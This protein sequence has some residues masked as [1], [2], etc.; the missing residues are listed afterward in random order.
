M[1][2]L[3]RAVF[4]KLSGNITYASQSVPVYDEKKSV[5]SSVDLYILLGRQTESDDIQDDD[6]FATTSTIEIEI[7]YKTSF[8]TSKEAVHSVSNQILQ[9]LIPTPYTSGLGVQDHFQILN[10]RRTSAITQG[11]QISDT[12]TILAKII[13]ISSQIVQQSP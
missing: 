3:L 10:L 12:Q 8:E 6:T 5:S 9:L 11:F 2:I 4:N 13:T 7:W 1:N